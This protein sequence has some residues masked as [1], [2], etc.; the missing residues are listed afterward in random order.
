MK[1]YLEGKFVTQYSAGM[2][3][4]SSQIL[5]DSPRLVTERFSGVLNKFICGANFDGVQQ[6]YSDVRVS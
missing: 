4:H 3:V 2:G 5:V 6:D 1:Y